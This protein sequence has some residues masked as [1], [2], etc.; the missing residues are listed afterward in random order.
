MLTIEP[1]LAA[2]RAKLPDGYGV[3]A[4]GTVEGGGVAAQKLH[5][6]VLARRR[7]ALRLAYLDL[8]AGNVADP[9]ADIFGDIVPA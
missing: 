9:G 3:A 1:A 8:Q 2:L 4:G 6:Q 5:L 7:P